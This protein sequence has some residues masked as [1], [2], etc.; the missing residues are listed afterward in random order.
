MPPSDVAAL[1][2]SPHLDVL[3]SASAICSSAQ[4]LRSL[5]RRLVAERSQVKNNVES[6]AEV[7]TSEQLSS[8]RMRTLVKISFLGLLT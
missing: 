7:S 5:K 2:G 6:F 3:I 4:P 8:P 1:F